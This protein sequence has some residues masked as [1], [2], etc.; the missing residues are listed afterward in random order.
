MHPWLTKC[1]SLLPTKYLENG[2]FLIPN[3]SSLNI[4]GYTGQTLKCSIYFYRSGRTDSDISGMDQ[5][6]LYFFVIPGN[7]QSPQG[8]RTE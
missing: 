3:N 2:C 7:K 6:P 8:P 5:I 4:C 1:V